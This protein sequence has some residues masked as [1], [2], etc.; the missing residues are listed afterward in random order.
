MLA[1]SSLEVSSKV[2]EVLV[3]NISMPDDSPTNQLSPIGWRSDIDRPK[4]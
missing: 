1:D 2:M 3:P 4:T